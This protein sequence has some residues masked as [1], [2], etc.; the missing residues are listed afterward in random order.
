MDEVPVMSW[1]NEC[2]L[3]IEVERKIHLILKTLSPRMY[4]KENFNVFATEVSKDIE[5]IF[6]ISPYS[7]IYAEEILRDILRKGAR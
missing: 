3:H 7:G 5:E 2:R 1:K 6:S 4:T